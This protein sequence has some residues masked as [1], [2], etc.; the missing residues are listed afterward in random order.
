MIPMDWRFWILFI[1]F[2]HFE[3][4]GGIL[5]MS[6]WLVD[7]DVIL[8]KYV[9]GKPLPSPISHHHGDMDPMVPFWAAGFWKIFTR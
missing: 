7:H 1:A 2:N 4:L 3:K 6:T 9:K 8:D 5:G